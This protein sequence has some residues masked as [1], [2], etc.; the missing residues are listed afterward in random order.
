MV[1]LSVCTIFADEMEVISMPF[2]AWILF[3]VLVLVM[4]VIDLKSP[5]H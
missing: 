3:Y 5:K 2:W 4:L 1:F